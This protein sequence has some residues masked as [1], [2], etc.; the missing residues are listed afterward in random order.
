MTTATRVIQFGPMIGLSWPDNQRLWVQRVD[1]EHLRQHLLPAQCPTP[2]VQGSCW[3][4]TGT[5]ASD[6]RPM[7]LVGGDYVSVRRM[8]YDIEYGPLS[9]R[10]FL[11]AACGVGRCCNP[12]HAKTDQ[13]GPV[14]G[15]T[16][17]ADTSGYDRCKY[18]H[19]LTPDNSYVY[20][21]RKM[22][23]L[24]RAAAEKRYRERNGAGKG[25]GPVR[26]GR[27]R[28]AAPGVRRARVG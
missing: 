21:G 5:V 27:A 9:G 3:L 16:T 11:V 6:G 26:V 4:W 12:R 13:R 15:Q 25:A 2:G 20:E 8:L 1:V 17:Y 14:Q 22:C 10:T 7:M 18:G 23:R 28:R 19:A 24:C